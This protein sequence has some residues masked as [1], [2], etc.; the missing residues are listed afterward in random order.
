LEEEATRGLEVLRQLR[1]ER[2][3]L[4]AVV[5]LDSSKPDIV[6]E[7]FRSG[8]SGV[9]C[10]NTPLQVLYKCIIAVHQGQVWAN[11]KELG[12]LLQA[13][14]LSRSFKS[15]NFK[16]L[17]LLSKREREVVQCVAEALTNQQIAERLNLSQ[18]TVKNYMFKIFE[19]LGVSSRLELIFYVL[20]RDEN[21]RRPSSS[22]GNGSAVERQR[23]ARAD[24][25]G[26]SVA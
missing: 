14:T 6:V 1:A 23:M 15:S 3:D 5:L 20:S 16:G 13:F 9:F 12:F 7:V 10:R 24:N 26:G 8:A 2:N 17:M 4:K 21:D 18:H 25:M 11:S 19:K 22:N